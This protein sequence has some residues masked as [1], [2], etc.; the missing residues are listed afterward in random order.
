M[1]SVWFDMVN[2]DFVMVCVYVACLRFARAN[3]CCYLK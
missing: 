3:G 1:G 2:K